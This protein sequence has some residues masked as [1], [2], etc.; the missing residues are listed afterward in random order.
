MV[1]TFSHLV[2]ESFSLAAAPRAVVFKFAP[3]SVI[4]P[5]W[6]KSMGLR[7]FSSAPDRATAVGCSALTTSRRS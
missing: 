4:V 3:P 2:G 5:C 1:C 7:Y 6:C